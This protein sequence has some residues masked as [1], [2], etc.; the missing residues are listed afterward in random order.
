MLRMNEEGVRLLK[1]SNVE[2]L[3]GRVPKK[4]QSVWSS[5]EW[6]KGWRSP[7]IRRSKVRLFPNRREDPNSL[8][9]LH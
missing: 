3:I 7:D 9:V 4:K 1:E 8:N 2:G 5:V 6:E